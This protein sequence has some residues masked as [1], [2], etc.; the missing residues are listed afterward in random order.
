MITGAPAA[1]LQL[2]E[3]APE[4]AASRTLARARI[5]TAAAGAVVV[6]RA[7]VVAQAEEPDEPDHEQAHIEDAEANHEDPTLSGHERDSS[8]ARGS[9]E[10]VFA[11]DLAAPRIRRRRPFAKRYRRCVPLVV[12]GGVVGVGFGM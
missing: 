12:F 3:R 10:G 8:A 7:L 6:G 2:A 9:A 4:A 11:D 1:L 5:A